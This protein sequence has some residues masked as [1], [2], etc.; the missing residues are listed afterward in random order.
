MKNG[1]PYEHEIVKEE[2]EPISEEVIR[3]RVSKDAPPISWTGEFDDLPQEKKIIYLKK[4]TSSL[5]HALD[6]MQEERNELAQVVKNQ[7]A[8][9][10]NIE[11]KLS[12]QASI[13]QQQ[14]MNDNA[15][16]EV[17][18]QEAVKLK[19]EL[20]KLKKDLER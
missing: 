11:T 4:L 15:E 10:E 8:T 19:G 6:L 9:I 2:Q 1:K 3:K 14:L 16:K 5:N 18:K 13:M 7:E 20:K 17:M 12:V